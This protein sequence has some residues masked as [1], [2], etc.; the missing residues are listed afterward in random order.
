MHRL[1]GLAIIATMLGGCAAAGA[2][3]ATPGRAMALAPGESV[4]LPDTASL[5][6]VGV[7]QDSRC[8]PKV[9]CIRAGDADVAFEFTPPAGD[10]TKVA[11]NL[12][13]SPAAI[14]GAWRMQLLALEFGEAAK[15]TVQIDAAP[16]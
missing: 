13:K 12:P 6:Y 1:V 7:T 10:V 2:R 11:V 9:Q 5:R 8:P 14:L 15:A 16:P 3:T 4:Q